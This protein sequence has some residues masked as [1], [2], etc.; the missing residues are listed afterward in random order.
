MIWKGLLIGVFVG[1]ATLPISASA[2]VK[3]PDSPEAGGR[4]Y[5]QNYKD[6][7]LASCIARA[8][9]GDPK[10]GKDAAYSAS[11]F[12][13]WTLYDVEKSSN[14]ID[15]LIERYLA[16]DYHNPLV[17]YQGVEFDLLKCFDMYHSKE[18]EAQV[19]QFVLNPNRTFRQDYPPAK[20]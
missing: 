15:N 7:L 19:K 11:V 12:I 2:D 9:K 6:M 14:A 5:G 17:E 3:T 20:R 13:E 18:L 4:T 1:M 8:Y 10:A 16:R